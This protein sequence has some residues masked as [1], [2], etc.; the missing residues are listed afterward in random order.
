M[1]FILISLICICHLFFSCAECHPLIDL[2]VCIQ[3]GTV[4]Y[5]AEMNFKRI[6]KRHEGHKL[7][8]LC[9]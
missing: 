8:T 6:K 9:Q 7:R 2:A 5:R 3:Q 1:L 4:S